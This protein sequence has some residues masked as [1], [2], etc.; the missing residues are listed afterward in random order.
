[1]LARP[2]WSRFGGL[3][4]ANR[5]F[6]SGPAATRAAIGRAAVALGLEVDWP[7]RKD[8]EDAE[9]R[10]HDLRA[11]NMA[12]F[13]LA[14]DDPQVYY[15]LGLALAVGTPLLLL[16]RTE[17]VIPFDVAQ[18]V[19][20]YAPGADL[21][22]FLIDAIDRVMYGLPSSDVGSSL[23]ATLGYAERLTADTRRAAPQGV[24]LQSLRKALNDPV[25]FNDALEVLC[26]Y[27]GDARLD[28]I[29]PRWPGA[30]PDVQQP[31][32]FAVMP[33]RDEHEPA[34]RIVEAAAHESG[35]RAM[36]NDQSE[37][38]QIIASIWEDICRATHVTVD[39]TGFNLNVCLELGLAHAIGRPT[40]VMGREGT[41]KSLE[42]R[43]PSLAKWRCHTYPEGARRSR[44]L[45]ATLTRFFSG[46]SHRKMTRPPWSR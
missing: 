35:I 2:V 37:R 10:W 21:D 15:E 46:S 28:V 31:R 18:H 36:R 6:F 24:A 27:L 7:G 41:E 26:G 3:V 34:Y 20:V 5:I 4:E 19:D 25:E 45:H 11:A 16:A 12:V 23:E 29:L 33:F 14:D 44:P 30:Y 43:L 22:G 17:T 38:Q 1:M 39:L 9:Q 40:I 13:D 32:S 8:T 42:T